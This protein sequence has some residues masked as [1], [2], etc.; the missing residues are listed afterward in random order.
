MIT[1]MIGVS[2]ILWLVL[3]A[4]CATTNLTLNLDLY[5]EDPTVPL[6]HKRV[7]KLQ[8]RL[9]A[10]QNEAQTLASDKRR[11]ADN[12]FGTYEDLYKLSL[13]LKE[14][15][16]PPSYDPADL[17]EL[18]GYLASYKETVREI[19]NRIKTLAVEAQSNLKAY[20]KIPTDNTQAAQLAELDVFGS[21]RAV[22]RELAKLGGPLGTDFEGSLVN[23][24]GIVAQSIAR[25]NLKFVDKEKKTETLQAIRNQVT[26]LALEIQ[27]LAAQGRRLSKEISANLSEAV[28]SAALEPAKMKNSINAVAQAAT[29]IAPS[30]GREDGGTTALRALLRSTSLLF[31]QV[32]RLQDPADPIWRIV[33]DPQNQAKWNTTFS[34]TYFYSEGNNSVIVV[35]DTPMSFRVQRG[36]NN[37]AAL[38]QGQLQVSR[39]IANAAISIAGAAAGL[40]I[41][42]VPGS[43]SQGK[44]STAQ[45]DPA[46]QLAVRKATVERSA[47]L[48]EGAIKGLQRQL[49]ML[50][51]EFKI[52]D[53]DQKPAVDALLSKFHS[54]LKAYDVVLTPPESK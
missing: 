40:P 12:L 39:A 22:A 14:G 24:W 36:N 7:V 43:T 44:D 15:S 4:G 18:R 31:S 20:L 2:A 3:L 34:E 17:D 19:E 47:A 42:N 33:S 27:E 37:P 6:T 50:R 13:L 28:K 52:V 30:I 54:V 16:S 29:F 9:D 48:R 8:E 53:V 5:K 21:I 49:I 11:L 26:K 10:A 32:D 38:I 35:R 41:P 51:D 1:H 25:D 46:E 23:S 45:R